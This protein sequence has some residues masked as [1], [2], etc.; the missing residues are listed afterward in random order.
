MQN[1]MPENIPQLPSQPV[2]EEH[3]ETQTC[4]LNA[5]IEYVHLNAGRC[6]WGREWEMFSVIRQSR[7][8]VRKRKS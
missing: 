3:N 6:L 1:V 7:R 4:H 8:E 5:L 2:R